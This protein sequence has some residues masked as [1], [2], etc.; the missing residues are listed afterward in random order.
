MYSL[1]VVQVLSYYVSRGYDM[2]IA[3]VSYYIGDCRRTIFD[4]RASVH[5]FVKSF[6]YRR[7][8]LVPA[9]V[10]TTR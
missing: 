5:R 9:V 10:S 3:R 8:V 6:F 2:G 7:I 4:G 1:V